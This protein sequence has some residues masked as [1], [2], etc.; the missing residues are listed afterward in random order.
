[1]IEN[2]VSHELTFNNCDLYSRDENS[3]LLFCNPQE[4][5]GTIVKSMASW[6]VEVIKKNLS[7]QY[8]KECG[9]GMDTG[10]KGSNVD[11]AGSGMLEVFKSKAKEFRKFWKSL[12]L[13]DR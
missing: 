8:F 5:D 12:P 9:P 13:P 1:M 7:L 3:H 10:V 4:Q 11:S 2:G 6:V